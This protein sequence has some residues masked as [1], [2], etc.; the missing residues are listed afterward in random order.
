MEATTPTA[1]EIDIEID[2]TRR[3]LLALINAGWST[4]VLHAACRLGLPE[5]LAA[6][7]EDPSTLAQACGADVA[8][9]T[10]LLRGLVALGACV[11]L[12]GDRFRLAPL[13]EL[14][15]RDHEASLREWALQ[16]G[17]PQ[18]Q[19][20]GELA[21]SVRTG[22]SWRL[23][24]QG[25]DSFAALAHD[26][27]DAQAFH[28][29][30]AEMTRPV[31][32]ALLRSLDWRGVRHLVDVGGGSGAMLAV[33]LA[34]L[35]EARGTVFD[36]PHAVQWAPQVLAQAGVA[37]RCTSEAGSFFEQVP[38]GGDVYLLKSVL[39]NWDDA[40]SVRI[41]RC[42]RAAMVAGARLVVVERL[43][44]QRL[45]TSVHDQLVAR[46]DLNMLVALSGRERR[47]SEFDTLFDDAGLARGQVA[48]LGDGW[49][50]IEASLHEA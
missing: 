44:A 48:A 6:G 7:G 12:G 47:L 17:G 49:S 16:V 20:W 23:R 14:L 11:D 26:A 34:G 8:G 35:P 22:Q 33:L 39:H 1:L 29:A 15:C 3:R 45:S 4:Q 5:A 24:H 10:R 50:A 40:R 2:E 25:D 37:A 31:A 41:L 42:C 19:R 32:A 43:V 13:G 46:S 27:G 36:Q 9:T 18:W 21:E 28:R 30:M 38:A